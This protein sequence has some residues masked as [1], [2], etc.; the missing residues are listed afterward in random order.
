MVGESTDSNMLLFTVKVVSFSSIQKE[1]NFI[2]QKAAINSSN[3]FNLL[4]MSDA[5]RS[6]L[7][8]NTNSNYDINLPG[9]PKTPDK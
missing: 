8:Y 1:Y 5:C 9:W 3:M 7:P 2:H 6:V 4:E